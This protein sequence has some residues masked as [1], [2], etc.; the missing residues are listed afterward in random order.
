MRNVGFC[1]SPSHWSLYKYGSRTNKYQTEALSR[2][3]R[4]TSWNHK[5][6]QVIGTEQAVPQNTTQNTCVRPSP[7]TP[8]PPPPVKL[9]VKEWG[10]SFEYRF[11][12]Y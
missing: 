5:P 4:G 1:I 11:V 12:F 7:V 8:T 9:S 6:T 2:S 3:T 10:T